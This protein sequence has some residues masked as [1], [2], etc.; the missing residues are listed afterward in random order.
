MAN[1]SFPKITR[2]VTMQD[3]ADS[4]GLSKTAISQALAGKG[5][6]S[7]ERRQMI[8]DTA[9]K[10]GYEPD[11]QARRLSTGRFENQIAIFSLDLDLGTETL[12]LS[13]VQQL[14]IAQGFDVSLHAFGFLPW[15][16]VTGADVL[17]RQVCRLKPRAIICNSRDL[18]RGTLQELEIFQRQGGAVVC[19]DES[20]DL[21]CDQVIFDRATNTRLATEYLLLA[22][23]RRIGIHPGHQKPRDPRFVSQRYDSFQATLKA[24]RIALRQQWI[25][26]S[27]HTYEEAGQDV[28]A[29]YLA[30]PSSK[31]PSALYIVNDHAAAAFVHAVMRAGLTVPDDVSVISD[32]DLPAAS[33]CF[34]PLA[35][36]TQPVQ[37]IAETVVELLTNRL[38]NPAAPQQYRIIKGQLVTRQSVVEIA[39]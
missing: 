26:Y 14:L 8:L 23:H 12:K 4:L 27:E 15:K 39:A 35:A 19:Y 17:L 21:Q 28:A 20:V 37:Q 2:S 11:V 29:Q 16:K 32:D 18:K 24:A 31:R 3:I 1:S 36:V 6:L 30:L 22:G 34:V 9:E 5:R 38:E 33:A 13:H 25:F 7:K 10:M